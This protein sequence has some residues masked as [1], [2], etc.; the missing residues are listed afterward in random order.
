M[1][2]YHAPRGK[3][4]KLCK[5]IAN[6]LTPVQHDWSKWERKNGWLRKTGMKI[7]KKV[8]IDHNF[9]C[10][11]GLEE[12]IVIE[13]FATLHCG[14]RIWNFNRITIGAFCMFAADVTLLNGG[15]DINSFE[16]FSGPLV[17]GKGCWIGNGARIVGPLTI[18]NNAII[19][20]GAVVIDDVPEGAVVAGVPARVIRNRE[21]PEKVWHMEGK[22]F[23]PKTF[24]LLS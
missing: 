12:N 18:G 15:H 9:H 13:D 16:P 11:T 7:G 24:E 23:S 10:L 17:I 20:A 4:R 19:G 2:T 6:F 8:V 14:L 1:H 22:Y 3:Y 5:V 21:L